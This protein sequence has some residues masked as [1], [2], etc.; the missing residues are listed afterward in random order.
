MPKLE[1]SQ[2]LFDQFKLRSQEKGF[3]SVDEYLNHILKEI[4]L[5]LREAE[6]D[7]SKKPSILSSDQEQI[8]KERLR[9]LG[10]ID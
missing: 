2:E 6:Q 8:V 9:N 4:A 10:Y 3:A 7:N 1:I 5:R